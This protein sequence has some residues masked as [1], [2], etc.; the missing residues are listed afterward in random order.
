[1]A[2]GK[3]KGTKSSVTNTPNSIKS[4]KGAQNKDNEDPASKESPESKAKPTRCKE[5]N[6]VCLS[7]EYHKTLDDDSIECDICKF[8][9]HKPCTN[10]TTDE[11]NMLKSGNENITYKCC[12]C[13]ESKAQQEERQAEL[14]SN[15]LIKNNERLMERF[16][17]FETK[18]LK[19]VDDRLEKKM[20]EIDEKNELHNAS[21]IT[22]IDS[23]ESGILQKVDQKIEESLRQF[24]EKNE[25]RMSEKINEKLCGDTHSKDEQLMI[26]DK[27]QKQI[28]ESF[29]EFKDREERKCNLIFFNIT[30]STKTEAAEAAQEDLIMIKKILT[31]TNPDLAEKETKNLTEKNLKRLGTISTKPNETQKPRPIK[32]SLP[33]EKTKYKVLNNSN[34]LKSFQPMQN[35]GLKPDMTKLQQKEDKALREELKRRKDM[36]EDVMIF[37]NK[38]IKR[39]DH[40][41]L[42]KELAEKNQAASKPNPEPKPK[43]NQQ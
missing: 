15:L 9:F 2:P 16:D 25:Q 8:W 23:L 12:G 33:D 11:W 22:K 42:K 36:N 20:H 1:M 39:A 37:R 43:P 18:I 27:I 10:T 40:A 14:F 35:I 30:E 41:T 5:C 28:S 24:E 19:K 38:I 6:N 29:D 34:N 3:P 31:H 4:K 7:E 32:V 26:E 13:L 21:I 17:T